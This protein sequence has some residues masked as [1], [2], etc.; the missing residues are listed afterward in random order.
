MPSASAV[1]TMCCVRPTLSLPP[2]T[3]SWRLAALPQLVDVDECGMM[4]LYGLRDDWLRWAKA[5][6]VVDLF[7]QSADE[8]VQ[9]LRKLGI[10]VVEDACE[11]LGGGH[12]WRRRGVRLLPEQANHDVRGWRG[13]RE[14]PAREADRGSGA[15]DAEPRTR[16]GW[17]DR[18]VGTNARMSEVHAALGLAQLSRMDESIYRRWVAA[19]EWYDPELR[20]CGVRTLAD[21]PLS[22]FV[23]PVWFASRKVRT[24][25]VQN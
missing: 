12:R 20:R 21:H 16:A 5:A 2:R 18:G 1:G 4:S 25:C 17:S 24:R 14:R 13:V 7:G 22:W 23:Y 15:G 3:R 10:P 11:A 6:V 8:Q 9:R 19:V